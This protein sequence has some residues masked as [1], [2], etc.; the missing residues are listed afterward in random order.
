MIAGSVLIVQA[1]RGWFYRRLGGVNGD[2]LGFTE[3][4]HRNFHTADVRVQELC[5]VTRSQIR[6]GS[7]HSTATGFAHETARESGPAG[8]TRA[9]SGIDPG[10]RHAVGRPQS[11]AAVLRGSWRGG[12]R[13]QSVSARSHA[14]DGGEFSGRRRGHHGVVPPVRDRAGDRRHG[15]GQVR[16]ATSR[17]S[18]RCRE[19][20]RKRAIEAGI[21]HAADGDLLGAGEMG[22]GNSHRGRGAAVRVHWRRSSRSRRARHGTRRR[23]RHAKSGR[24][25]AGAGAASS[26]SQGCDRRAGGAG[27]L[28]DRG[29]RRV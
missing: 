2:C 6:A 10:D 9:A 16:R 4:L 8:G 20:R 27:R 26:R 28:R 21:A 1:S 3:Q 25:R 13:R 18:R 24:D 15:R 11:D 12:G 7:A 17:A 23:G 14:P 5:M 29:D 19:R 22:I